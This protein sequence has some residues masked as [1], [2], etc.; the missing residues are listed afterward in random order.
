[1]KESKLFL[2]VHFNKY[3]TA[4]INCVS[5]GDVKKLIKWVQSNP[6]APHIL[7]NGV[8]LNPID[9]IDKLNVYEID[10]ISHPIE[11]IE[12]AQRDTLD[13]FSLSEDDVYGE[14]GTDVTQKFLDEVK[15]EKKNNNILIIHGHNESLL[16]NVKDFLRTVKLNPIILR[17]QVNRG[18]TIIEKLERLSDCASFAVV[19]YTS[20]DIGYEKNGT[21]RPRAR[22]N[23]IFEHG[24][25]SGKYGR[26]HVATIAEEGMDIPSDISGVIYIDKERWHFDLAKELRS[27]GF[28][29][30]LNEL[31]AN[32]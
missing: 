9:K 17:E 26:D 31:V 21:P 25:F 23:V 10:T 24:F 15:K 18:D 1:M 29:I 11:V 6:Q 32:V 30:D 22:Q 8:V 3:H 5:P 7:S 19:L 28:E 16:L 4:N 13:G 14:F 2:H 20:C 27:A 12:K